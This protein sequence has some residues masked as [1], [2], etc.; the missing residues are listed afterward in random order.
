M[1]QTARTASHRSLGG[2]ETNIWRLKAETVP[3]AGVQLTEMQVLPARRWSLVGEGSLAEA[4][5]PPKVA[6]RLATQP[7][8]QGYLTSIGTVGPLL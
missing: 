8:R 2:S 1:P 3:A 7:Y 4:R 5:L 6:T